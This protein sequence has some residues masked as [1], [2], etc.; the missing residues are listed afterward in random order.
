MALVYDHLAFS[1]YKL[2]NIKRAAQYTKDLLQNGEYGVC[3]SFLLSMII[4]HLE[5]H[6]QRALTNMAYFEKLRTESPEQYAD[7]EDPAT[8]VGSEG[9]ELS[10]TAAYEATCREGQPVVSSHLATSMTVVT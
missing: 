3:V 5:P 7:A 2:G 9:D 1:E 6:H 4:H 10:E 8:M